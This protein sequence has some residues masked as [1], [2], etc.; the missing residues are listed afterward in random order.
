MRIILTAKSIVR[1]MTEKYL[2]L[3]SK[4]ILWAIG[5]FILAAA[6]KL[7]G[8]EVPALIGLCGA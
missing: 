2:P 3:H 7:V 5:V 6:C 1:V 8:V 4:F